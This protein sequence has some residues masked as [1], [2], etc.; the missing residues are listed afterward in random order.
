MF[1]RINPQQRP[2]L[3][4]NRILIR[5][6]P[7]LQTPRLRI[8]HQPAPPTPLNSRQLS[9]HHLLQLAHTT[10]SLLNSTAQFPTGGCSASL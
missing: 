3:P 2:R 1:P 10:I 7:N 4:P 6:R 9:I 8:P 5:I